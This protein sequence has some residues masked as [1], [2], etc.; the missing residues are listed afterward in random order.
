MDQESICVIARDRLAE[1]LGGPICRGMR[2]NVVVENSPRT[3][4]HDYEHV[5]ST[6]GRDH[7]RGI[8]AGD[9]STRVI[10]NERCPAH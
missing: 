9:K 10:A 1:L 6:E 8:I 7:D 3:D 4:L 2:G 5:E